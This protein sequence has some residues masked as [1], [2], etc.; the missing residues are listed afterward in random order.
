MKKIHGVVAVAILVLV[1]ACF[2]SCGKVGSD[3]ELL[4]KKYVGNVFGE[5]LWCVLTP[6]GNLVYITV[7]KA[8]NPTEITSI[9]RTGKYPKRTVQIDET[10]SLHMVTLDGK[11]MTP[12]EALEALEAAQQ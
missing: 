12:E 3:N 8:D 10:D 11:T 5:E 2:A 1:S 6:E 4:S 7:R 9:T